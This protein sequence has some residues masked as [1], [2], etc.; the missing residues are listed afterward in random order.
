MTTKQSFKI[1]SSGEVPRYKCSFNSDVRFFWLSKGVSEE[2][3]VHLASLAYKDNKAYQ[4]EIKRAGFTLG[5][6]GSKTLP[7]GK[8]LF[9][10]EWEQ[11]AA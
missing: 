10:Y 9:D 7:S 4:A 5:C 8:R 11:V 3:A 2:T 6:F 1:H